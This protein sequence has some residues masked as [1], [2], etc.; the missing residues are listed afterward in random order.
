MHTQIEKMIKDHT[1]S[2]L[3]TDRKIR[4]LENIQS[5]ISDTIEITPQVEF[6]WFSL[7]KE[8]DQEQ[9][10]IDLEFIVSPSEFV[11]TEEQIN[12]VIFYLDSVGYAPIAT[13]YGGYTW[14]YQISTFNKLQLLHDTKVKLIFK[15]PKHQ[16]QEYIVSTKLKVN[17]D[18]T[19]EVSCLN[20]V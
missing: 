15:F 9:Y 11:S 5:F 18:E 7:W 16:E 2:L 13:M 1:A 3:L 14:G 4:T 8:Y 6:S 17:Q 19:F 20:P 10:N 12:S